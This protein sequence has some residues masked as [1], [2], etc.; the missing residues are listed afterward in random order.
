MKKALLFLGVAM[1]MISCDKTDDNK[2]GLKTAYINT[3]ELVKDYERTKAEDE[4]FKVKSTEMG[5]PLDAKFKAFQSEASEFQRNAQVKGQAWAQQKGMELQRREQELQADQN[6][7]MQQFQKE[8]D[9]IRTLIVDEIKTFVRDFGKK[10][11]YDFIFN[12]EDAST[13]LYAKDSYN[14]T[15]Q[16]L[17]SMN[18]KYTKANGKV[19]E[20]DT[21][22]KKE[23]KK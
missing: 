9:S 12:T 8:S 18:E 3:V 23:D 4:K 15:A 5:R 6:A 13:I 7:I 11:G 20:K 22:V 10:E 17:K 1:A 21:D 14:I 19:E 2:S 16:V